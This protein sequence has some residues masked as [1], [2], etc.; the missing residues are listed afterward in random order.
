MSSRIKMLA[1]AASITIGLACV[2]TAEA[3]NNT[4]AWAKPINKKAGHAFYTGNR[5]IN[6]SYSFR[7][8]NW[9][10]VYGQQHNG[11][12]FRSGHNYYTTRRPVV[13]YRHPVVTTPAPIVTYPKAVVITPNQPRTV[14]YPGPGIVIQPKV[15]VK[16]ATPKVSVLKSWTTP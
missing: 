16:P 3:G 13:T 8:K 12:Q 9:R 1:L 6:N 7:S 14:V 4:W 10:Q 11:Y 5:N 15:L 2:S